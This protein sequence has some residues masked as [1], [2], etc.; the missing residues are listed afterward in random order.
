MVMA[1]RSGG[2]EVGINMNRE[3]GKDL[4]NFLRVCGDTAGE[5]VDYFSPASILFDR[6]DQLLHQRQRLQIDLLQPQQTGFEPQQS[7]TLLPQ[8]ELR[9]VV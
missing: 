1:L 5:K 8:A 3:S 7:I 4:A 6:L 9:Q 2:F